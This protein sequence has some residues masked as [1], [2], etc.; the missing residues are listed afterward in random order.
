MQQV[1]YYG[2]QVLESNHHGECCGMSCSISEKQSW[3]NVGG[4]WIP[5]HNDEFQDCSKMWAMLLQTCSQYLHQ[6]LNVLKYLQIF[7][8]FGLPSSILHLS[9]QL[10]K[11]RP[12]CFKDCSN[13]CYRWC[14]LCYWWKNVFSLIYNDVLRA[15]RS[16]DGWTSRGLIRAGEFSHTRWAWVEKRC[17]WRV[18]GSEVEDPR[19]RKSWSTRWV[20][21]EKWSLWKSGWG[22]EG[23]LG[24]VTCAW[25]R[26][27]P[28]AEGL[29]AGRPTL[30]LSSSSARVSCSNCT[31]CS[32]TDS[33]RAAALSHCS[34][35]TT[36][37]RGERGPL[38]TAFRVS[39]Q[40][41]HTLPHTKSP[42]HWS[43]HKLSSRK[44]LLQ[45]H[46]QV[47]WG[48]SSWDG[49]DESTTMG[50][51][52][53]IGSLVFLIMIVQ[54]AKSLCRHVKAWWQTQKLPGFCVNSTGKHHISSVV[55][56]SN[57]ICANGIYV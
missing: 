19:W 12:Q 4:K 52:N 8:F 14:R 29:V 15:G 11:F 9:M 27:R 6:T 48:E 23:L 43:S 53:R 16:T 36:Q 39:I 5:W 30:L 40:S 37:P 41:M 7:I 31:S 47:L 35:H 50:L 10:I 20:L 38:H 51:H 26:G 21:W 42:L 28:R 54:H 22:S 34:I 24:C 25:G 57:Q 18:N 13:F 33:S 46:I 3:F 1:T 44:G 49:W 56:V 17:E 32:L 55:F 45:R 2:H